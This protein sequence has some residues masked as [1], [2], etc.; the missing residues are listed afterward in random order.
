MSGSREKV[1]IAHRHPDRNDR[2]V[3]RRG[4]PESAPKCCK[5]KAQRVELDI[6]STTKAYA[7]AYVVSVTSPNRAPMQRPRNHAQPNETHAK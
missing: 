3:K 5:T 4:A 2:P 7:M 1:R 6:P